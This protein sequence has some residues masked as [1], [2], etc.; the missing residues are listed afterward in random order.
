MKKL[1]IA[2]CISVASMNVAAQIV[3]AAP[4]STTPTSTAISPAT[5]PEPSPTPLPEPIRQPDPIPEPVK[6]PEPEPVRQPDT[7]PE[8]VKQPEPEPVRQPD[9]IPEP[10]KQPSSTPAVGLQP[11]IPSPETAKHDKLDKP[12]NKP[13]PLPDRPIRPE[14]PD[15]SNKPSNPGKPSKPDGQPDGRPDKPHDK[16]NRPDNPNKPSKPDGHPDGRPDKPHDKPNRPDNPDKPSKPDGHPNGRP[17]KP[18]D[19]P[20]NPPDKPDKPHQ[21]NDQPR[22]EAPN[23]KPDKHPSK[24][25]PRPNHNADVYQE[26]VVSD[27][28]FE[29]AAEYVDEIV[30]ID[31][32]VVVYNGTPI[33][34]AQPPTPNKQQSI[35][36]K[37]ADLPF[38]S[39]ILPH[40]VELE[41][42][43][44]ASIYYLAYPEYQ[45][46]NANILYNNQVIIESGYISYI[47]Y[48][49]IYY[50]NIPASSE[51]YFYKEYGN[52]YVDYNDYYLL[53]R[54]MLAFASASERSNSQELAR[55]LL[56]EIRCLQ[57]KL[58][59]QDAQLVNNNRSEF[60]QLLET[61]GLDSAEISNYQFHDDYI[62]N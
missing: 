11:S 13:N 7:I 50:K 22:P 6:Q 27:Y 56:A 60:Y 23:N 41:G 2:L 21:P 9:P 59:I 53:G 12:N 18:H 54:L 36:Y 24:P 1:V 57:A 15:N 40:A 10:V 20:S 58:Q 30:E 38:R 32:P 35:G 46:Q 52:Y 5:T 25:R 48:P 49:S 45:Q 37:P 29:E 34:E 43:Q 61:L 51:L 8:P 3:K 28:Y 19:K 62:V 26:E 55:K 17:D 39:I 4:D 47:F 31:W 42:Y 14:S 16:P 33:A 44:Q